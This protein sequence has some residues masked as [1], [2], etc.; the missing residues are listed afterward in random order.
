[1]NKPLQP[2]RRRRAALEAGLLAISALLLLPAAAGARDFCCPCPGAEAVTIDERNNMM[3]SMKCS[4]VCNAPVL[5][6]SGA[7]PAAPVAAPAARGRVQ[8]FASADCSG[9]AADVASSTADLGAQI[10]GGAFSFRL[11][12]GEAARVWSETGYAGTGTAPVGV[13]ICVSPGFAIRSVRIG[14]G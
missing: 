8:L 9:E 7:C 11:A 12:A 4:L 13:G 10:A 14:A 3:A 1:M 6:E 2:V 5:A